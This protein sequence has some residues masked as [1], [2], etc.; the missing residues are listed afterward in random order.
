MDE[1]T[2]YLILLIFLIT[3][4]VIPIVIHDYMMNGPKETPPHQK[5]CDTLSSNIGSYHYQGKPVPDDLLTN[6]TKQC[7]K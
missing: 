4:F 7:S 1:S 2:T 3:A 5:Y 6:Y